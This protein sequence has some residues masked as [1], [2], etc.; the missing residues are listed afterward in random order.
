MAEHI[1]VVLLTDIDTYVAHLK[2][3]S[4]QAPM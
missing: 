4:C 1:K 2:F 3:Q